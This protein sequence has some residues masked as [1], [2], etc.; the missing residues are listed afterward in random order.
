V[1]RDVIEQLEVVDVHDIDSAD[2]G[3]SFIN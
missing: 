3:K 1:F 2:V